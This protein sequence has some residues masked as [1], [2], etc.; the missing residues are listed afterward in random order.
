MAHAFCLPQT[1]HSILS[2]EAYLFQ[3][4]VAP[5]HYH[6]DFEEA[7]FNLHEH[8]MLQASAGWHSYYI[9]DEKHKKVSGAIHFHVSDGVARSPLRSPFGSAEF[10]ES[11][12]ATVL[13]EFL[14]FFELKLKERGVS[15]IMIKNYPQAYAESQSVLLQVFLL[16][17][18]YSIVNAEAGSVI[19]VSTTGT[20]KIFHRSERRKLGKA[21]EAGFTFKKL[22]NESL[23]D[24][25][26]FIH[27]CR[28]EK[29]Y[30]LSMPFS[31]L[32]EAISRFPERYLLFGVFQHDQMAAAS[33]TIQVKT[34]VLYDFY[35]DH[36][37]AFDHFSPVVLLVEGLYNFCCWNNIELIDV[38]TS[39]VEGLP[40]F[41]LL[42]FKRFLGGK[43]TPKL[44]FEKILA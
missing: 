43:P 25:Y 15:R 44:T 6:F 9:L 26:T 1:G 12:P 19:E 27:R 10:S 29:G 7:L 4:G 8:R 42:H 40:N 17:L 34:K 21:N 5:P 3:E 18:N 39:A 33:I 35:H 41:N 16:N 14:K 30:A 22:P 23:Q 24:V 28:N 38:G 13:F 2:L 11:L 37:A 32:R 31:D 36:D 20:G